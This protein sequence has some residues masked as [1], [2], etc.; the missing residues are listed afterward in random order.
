[1]QFIQIFHK[2]LDQWWWRFSEGYLNNFSTELSTQIFDCCPRNFLIQE[3]QNGN[4]VSTSH[5]IRPVIRQHTTLTSIIAW[6]Y[7]D[8]ARPLDVSVNYPLV[9][10]IIHIYF[11]MCF[12]LN[13]VLSF[14]T[15]SYLSTKYY[16]S[17]T[18]NSKSFVSMV[19]LRIKW[20]FELTV[21]F[22]H[23]MLGKW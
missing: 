8:Q 12:D 2:L 21:H 19:L 10:L 15:F 20:K 16:R 18:V 17:G 23:E 5:W 14:F 3:K 7:R 9:C 6:N 4:V 1:M 11:V 13:D 22:K